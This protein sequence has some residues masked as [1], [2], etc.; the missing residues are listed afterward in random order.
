MLINMKCAN[1]NNTPFDSIP[2]HKSDQTLKNDSLDNQKEYN[3]LN[4]S[5]N[6]FYIDRFHDTLSVNN[7]NLNSRPYR[8]S[9]TYLDINGPTNNT[10]RN[11]NSIVY[12][13]F[14]YLDAPVVKEIQSGFYNMIRVDFN[15]NYWNTIGFDQNGNSNNLESTFYGYENRADFLQSGTANIIETHQS[16]NS[17]LDVSQNGHNNTVKIYQQ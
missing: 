17:T 7:D 1:L 2:S 4:I 16:Q 10:D 5:F 6:Y 3:E 8:T 12:I 11:G 14:P 13:H 9:S 15:Y